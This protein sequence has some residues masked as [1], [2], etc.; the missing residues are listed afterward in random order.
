M[1][2]LESVLVGLLVAVA[3]LFLEYKTGLF[4]P[5]KEPLNVLQKLR[6]FIEG[7]TTYIA[8]KIFYTLFTIL[9][10]GFYIIAI[11]YYGVFT[12]FL[13]SPEARIHIEFV[14]IFTFLFILT[15]YWIR[16]IFNPN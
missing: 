9:H 16:D 7:K 6:T 12:L 15:G 5:R 13:L 14:I 1:S 4:L 3:A 11:I 2:L 8:S 10:Y